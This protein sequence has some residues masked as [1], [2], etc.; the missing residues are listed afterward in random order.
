MDKDSVVKRIKS[1]DNWSKHRER[2]LKR[3]DK[4]ERK[5]K[6]IENGVHA[7]LDQIEESDGTLT[8][9]DVHSMLI[10]VLNE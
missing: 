1:T 3:I 5:A 9:Q 10:Q 2:W 6:I 7:V 4:A 8:L